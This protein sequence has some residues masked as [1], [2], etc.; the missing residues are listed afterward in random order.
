MMGAQARRIHPGILLIALL[1]F[2]LRLYALDR[3]DI[4]GDEAFSIWLSSQPLPQ[5]V[6]GGADTHPPLYPFLLYLWL[7]L[8]GPSPLVVRFLSALVGTLTIPVVYAL[9]C[10]AFGRA[11]GKLAAFLAAI[12]PILVY[13]SQET[14]MYGLVTLLAA[15]SVYWAM[16]IFQEPRRAGAWLAYFFTTLAAAYTHYYAF[17]VIL[18]ED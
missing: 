12:S 11:A 4:W 8:G 18:A 16:R 9:G 1:A 7:G 15:A 3:Q 10:R 17:F 5:V 2:G 13:Y 14:R 6:A